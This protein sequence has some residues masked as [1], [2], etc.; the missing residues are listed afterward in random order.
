MAAPRGIP[1]LGI[2]P[3][4]QPGAHSFPSRLDDL[5]AFDLILCRNVMI[6]FSQEVTR[7]VAGQFQQCLTEDGWLLVGHAEANVDVFK[8]FQT[9][10]V[11]DAVLY[12]NSSFGHEP[13][14]ASG[15]S[16]RLRS[17]ACD[18]ADA[19]GQRAG[20]VRRPATAP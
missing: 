16:A 17:C 13:E 2:I 6:Y 7:R 14:P 12:R 9:V 18:V 4:P 19:T 10:N 15:G 8:Q 3:A 5:L 1:S 11:G 20:A